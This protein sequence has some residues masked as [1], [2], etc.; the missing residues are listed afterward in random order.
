[1]LIA[2]KSL[3]NMKAF[4]DEHT[5]LPVICALPLFSSTSVCGSLSTR[6]FYLISCAIFHHIQ[7]HFAF[8]TT[9]CHYSAIISGS[10]SQMWLSRELSWQT[11]IRSTGKMWVRMGADNG[12]TSIL[13]LFTSMSSNRADLTQLRRLHWSRWHFSV[14]TRFELVIDARYWFDFF[15]SLVCARADDELWS[16]L[17]RLP[18]FHVFFGFGHLSRSIAM[19]VS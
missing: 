6:Y 11:W 15:I 9:L 18:V 17:L 19:K 4:L 12:H 13:F 8:R 7:D 5:L 14:M 10:S 1:M 3:F 2:A 16:E